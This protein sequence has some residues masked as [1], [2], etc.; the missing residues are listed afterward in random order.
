[1]KILAETHECHDELVKVLNDE[2]KILLKKYSDAFMELMR[3][4]CRFSYDQGYADAVSERRE[5]I[6]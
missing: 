4:V 5:T 2:Q 1:M 3:E 6:K